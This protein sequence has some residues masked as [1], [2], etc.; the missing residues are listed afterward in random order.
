MSRYL[1]PA[2][3]D[4][5]AAEVATD[6]IPA[7]LKNVSANTSKVLVGAD[8][9]VESSLT[10][11]EKSFPHILEKIQALWGYPEMDYYFVRLTID[12]RGDR[13]GFP[14]EVWDDLQMLTRLHSDLFSD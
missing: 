4:E 1:F 10:P 11:L 6:A 14:A 12:D 8:N 9:D 2:L 7:G 13:Q 3:I 5:V